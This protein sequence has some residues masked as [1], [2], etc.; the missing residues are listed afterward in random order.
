LH[1]EP[2][3]LP[4][5]APRI[6]GDEFLDW[7]GE[8]GGAIQRA[9]DVVLAHHYLAFVQSGFVL[10]LL[11]RVHRVFFLVG[12]KAHIMPK[13]PPGACRDVIAVR[14]CRRQSAAASRTRQ[15]IFYRPSRRARSSAGAAG[16][17]LWLCAFGRADSHR[18]VQAKTTHGAGLL[19]SWLCC[20]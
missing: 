14:K 4:Y 8:L 11:V 2:W 5:I 13:R 16:W 19:L 15:I 1:V 3:A 17:Q 10:G 18:V 12:G 6:A 20:I 7:L 9:G